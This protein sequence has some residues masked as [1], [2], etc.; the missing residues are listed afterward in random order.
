MENKIALI[1]IVVDD[2]TQSVKVNALLHEYSEYV[3][4][5][6]GIPCREQQISVIS[7]ILDA[8]NDIIASL[9]KKL[10]DVQ[11]VQANVQYAK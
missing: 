9:V 8:P 5:R 11:N 4:G 1:G 6:M 7:V 3:L 10:E 2:L